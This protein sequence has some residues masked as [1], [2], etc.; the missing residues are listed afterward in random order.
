MGCAEGAG[1][2]E[3]VG[4][5]EAAFGVGVD[6]FDGL[7]GASSSFRQGRISGNFT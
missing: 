1:V 5:D 2:G 6:D 4:E 7:A 3:S